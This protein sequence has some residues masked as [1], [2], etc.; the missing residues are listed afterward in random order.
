MIFDI[1]SFSF[2]YSRSTLNG[3]HERIYIEIPEYDSKI[4]RRP[5]DFTFI[6]LFFNLIE[7]AHFDTT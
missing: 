6:M 4:F 1:I 2:A 3:R 7:C 5:I